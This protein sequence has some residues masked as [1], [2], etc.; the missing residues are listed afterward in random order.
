MDIGG[1]QRAQR[2]S[3]GPIK[4]CPHA[5]CGPSTNQ[6]PSMAERSGWQTQHGQA[7]YGRDKVA[8]P[9]SEPPTTGS[10]KPC[11]IGDLGNRPHSPSQSLHAAKPLSEFINCES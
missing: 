9:H 7:H 4:V 6:S 3:L 5:G 11:T 8:K 1:Q 10:Y 2:P